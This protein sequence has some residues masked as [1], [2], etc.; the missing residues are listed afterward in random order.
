MERNKTENSIKMK[1][2]Y[3]TI[4]TSYRRE[5]V[6]SF[7]ILS[8]IVAFSMSINV[9]QCVIIAIVAFVPIVVALHLFI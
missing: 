3:N 8:H 9:F 1:R 6:T 2:N 7:T 4:A 5:R